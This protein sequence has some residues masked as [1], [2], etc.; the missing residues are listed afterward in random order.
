M[1]DV[2]TGAT[3]DVGSGQLSNQVLTAYDRV[4]RF[5]LREMVVFDKLPQVKPGNLT[6]PGNPVN[7]K[8]WSDLSAATTPLDENVD[9]DAVGLSD[10]SVTVTPDEYGNAV[11]VTL[12]IQTDDYL[13][14]F[15][16]DVA[17]IVNY[18]MVDTIDQLARTALGGAT[19]ITYVGQ[20]SRGA[21][22]SSN[23]L[24]A[25]IVRQRRADLRGASAL[26]VFGSDYAAIIHP[27]VAYD[28]KIETGE[29]AWHQQGDRV[30]QEFRTAEIGRFAG[31]T[32]LESPRAELVADG[33]SSTTD[34]YVS[35][36]MGQEAFAKAESVPA[37][38]VMGP[39]TDKLMRFR[40]LGWH[41]YAGWDTLREASIQVVESASANGDN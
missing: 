23:V 24:T 13:I 3:S 16:S 33:G 31:F 28:L 27:D 1:A 39:V 30:Q 20:A 22:T 14:G 19:N 11:L 7:F 36:F 10:S 25:N 4:A 2:L 35:Y 6:S 38:I 12:R 40:P 18:N 26:P 9:V 29:N 5:A 32:F 37:H 15:D 17:N 34:V 41:I 21:I 8:F